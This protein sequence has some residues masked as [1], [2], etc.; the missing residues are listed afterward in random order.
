M[1]AAATSIT[2]SLANQFIGAQGIA[3]LFFT[4]IL[5]AEDTQR[6]YFAR[7]T[8]AAGDAAERLSVQFIF[9]AL[10]EM[11]ADNL[12]STEGADVYDW[13]VCL[14]IAKRFVTAFVTD[15]WM[16]YT[17][18]VKYSDGTQSQ[19]YYTIDRELSIKSIT[20]LCRD[21]GYGRAVGQYLQTDTE[22]TDGANAMASYVFQLNSA[23][24]KEAHAMLRDG[25]YL[26]KAEQWKLAETPKEKKRLDQQCRQFRAAC[27]VKRA[28][29]AGFSFDVKADFRGRLYYVA[30]MLNP[31]AGGVAGYLLTN[32]EQVTY[33][34]TAS[35][36]QF[37]AVLTN[38]EKLGAACGL[39]NYSDTP[40][41]FYAATLALATSAPQ[42]EKSS[43]ERE[44]AKAYLMPK[45]YGAGDEASK[46]R[47]AEI[48]E[49]KGIDPKMA[50]EIVDVLSKYE[51]LDV[52]KNASST[53]ARYLA[54]EHNQQL[55]WISPSGFTVVQNYWER[56]N[57]A[58]KVN[59]D[60]A[61]CPTAITFSIKTET[62]RAS[63]E[64]LADDATADEIDVYTARAEANA[65]VKACDVA[66]AAN[67]VQ[68]LDAAFMAKC[69]ATYKRATGKTFIAIHDSC[70]FNSRD[71]IAVFL[72]IAWEVFRAMANSA[73][74]KAMRKEI[75]LAPANVHWL[76]EAVP[77]FMAEE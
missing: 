18:A 16:R 45:A 37:I 19:A 29:P 6:E 28:F 54:R 34:S 43:P 57:H 27:E 7:L 17:A 48:A 51:G 46:T 35:F 77:M 75:G 10:A 71:E 20:V 64:D 39:L 62:V 1:T 69:L 8:Q 52:V 3:R 32:S 67:F 61:C 15:G 5:A 47:A 55:E 63:F 66:A 21:A 9:K 68:S 72:P 12:N 26:T 41:D 49:E 44:I 23:R 22:H 65:K 36:A 58:W 40:S 59:G 60:T 73:E 11:A 30:G 76:L 74:I 70:T 4:G 50:G 53:R 2:L 14:P 33:D 31:Q 42:V 13:S 38:D 56:R 24:G 25:M